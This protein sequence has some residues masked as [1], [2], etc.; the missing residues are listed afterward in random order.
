MLDTRTKMSLATMVQAPT[1]AMRRAMGLPPTLSTR[2]HGL[3]WELDL[4]EGIDFAIWLL[5]AFERRTIAAYSRYVG[6]GSIVFDIGANIGAHTLPLAVRVG[7]TGHVYAFEPVRW[8]RNKLQANLGLN[9]SLTDRVTVH[10]LLLTERDGAPVPATIHASWPLG[11]AAGVHPAL[12]ARRLPT[13][14]AGAVTVDSFVS[15]EQLTRLDL[16]KLDVDGH[17]C[18]V[19]RGARNTL[20]RFRPV[21]VLELSPYILEE[22]GDSIDSLLRLLKDGRYLLYHLDGET[23][24]P[25]EA[26]ALCRLIPR[27]GGINAVARVAAP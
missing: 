3:Q 9:G 23:P 6:P 22:H 17:E 24:L 8:A 19:L 7:A 10:Q 25:L 1:I 14:G 2:R 13:D 18:S 27:G 20:R 15:A 26:A 11:S 16:I 12:R 5:G 4:R 21:I